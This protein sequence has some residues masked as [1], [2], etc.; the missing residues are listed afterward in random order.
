LFGSIKYGE[1]HPHREHPDQKD[2]RR[3]NRR[4]REIGNLMPSASH[5]DIERPRTTKT[6]ALAILDE[7]EENPN[8]TLSLPLLEIFKSI[9]AADF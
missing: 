3:L 4:I 7:I 1:R 2:F 5:E 8:T 6:P 9:L